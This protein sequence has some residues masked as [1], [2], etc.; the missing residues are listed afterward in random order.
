MEFAPRH[1]TEFLYSFE[2]VKEKIRAFEGCLFLEL[3]QD[4]KKPEVFFTYSRW[5][6][7][8]A[9]ESYR[10]SALFKEV[11]GRTKPLFSE[12]AEAWSVDTLYQLN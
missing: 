12:K 8:E 2:E 3:Y 6:N 11:W 5:I 1:I 9:L 4:K 10:N 7:E